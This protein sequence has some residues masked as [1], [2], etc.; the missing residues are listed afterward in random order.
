[1]AVKVIKSK[2]RRPTYFAF[3]LLPKQSEEEIKVYEERDDTTLYALVLVFSGVFIFL[4]LF[5]IKK[6]AVDVRA[7]SIE[8][9]IEETQEVINT[10]N[11]VIATHGE[12]F[13]KSNLLEEPL[14]KD[15]AL[16]R[17]LEISTLL[18][19]DEGRI[20]AYGKKITGGFSLTFE[21]AEY[22]NAINILGRAS[23]ITELREPYITTLS[24]DV[25]TGT[26]KAIMTFK[27]I[28]DESNIQ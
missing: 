17:L 16:S 11:D 9:R 1:M 26:I 2:Y 12:I 5:L 18:T 27:I 3:N 25:V 13:Q 14:T 15:I 20:I 28:Q 22:Q 19:Q 10:Y 24:E 23:G 4:I 7:T 21:V 8:N 6:V